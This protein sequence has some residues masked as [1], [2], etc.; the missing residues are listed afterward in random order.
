MRRIVAARRESR[1]TASRAAQR[2]KFT[3][4]ILILVYRRTTLVT[5]RF[6]PE[7]VYFYDISGHLVLSLP[8]LP[9]E[10]E[11]SGPIFK[12]PVR[13]LSLTA[14]QSTWAACP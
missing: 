8:V 10:Y 5:V 2:F 11:W 14:R 3:S 6:S 1:Q 7:S 4:C 13:D 9:Q 12:G